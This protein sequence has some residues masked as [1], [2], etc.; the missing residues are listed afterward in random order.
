L[1]P[2]GNDL[3]LA[4]LLAV[5]GLPTAPLQAA[6]NEYRPAFTEVFTGCFSLTPKGHNIHKAHLFLALVTLSST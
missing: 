5:L 1:D 2:F 3:V 4:P 6:F